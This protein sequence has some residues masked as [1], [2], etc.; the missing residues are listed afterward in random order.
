MSQDLAVTLPRLGVVRLLPS[1]AEPGLAVQIDALLV[2]SFTKQAAH[3][4]DSKSCS[5]PVPTEY[6]REGLERLW[7]PY[8]RQWGKRLQPCQ[9]FVIGNDVYMTERTLSLLNRGFDHF[10]DMHKVVVYWKESST[11]PSNERKLP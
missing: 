10:I 3:A 7:S 6:Y 4:T 5:L 2:S 9:V 1:A 8:A 11:V